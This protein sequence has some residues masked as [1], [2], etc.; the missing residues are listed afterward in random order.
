MPMRYFVIETM[1]SSSYTMTVLYHKYFKW[2]MAQIPSA[3]VANMFVLCACRSLGLNR[4]VHTEQPGSHGAAWFTRSSLVHQEQPGS[5][6]AAWFTLS[7]LVHTE[8]PGSHGAAW[9]TR[10]NRVHTEQPG[11]PGVDVHSFNK[12]VLSTAM[13]SA[14]LDPKLYTVD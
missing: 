11:S 5:H 14:I 2:G 12:P 9:F 1:Q 10:S 4:L 13:K 6:G 7:S 8:Q 3:D